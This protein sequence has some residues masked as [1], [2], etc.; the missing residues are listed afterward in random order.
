VTQVQSPESIIDTIRRLASAQKS[1]LGAPAYSRWV[2][3][4]VGRV[5]AAISY[6]AGLTPNQVTT[7][8]AAFSATG[9]AV[10]ALVSPRW[11]TGLLVTICLVL[12]Y[13]FD[14]ADGQLARL[15]GGGSAVGEWLD[16]MVDVTK[17]T[18]L[19]LAVLISVYRFFDLGSTLWYLVPICFAVVNTTTFFGMIL[20]EQLY[21]ARGI[22]KPVGVPASRLRSL[23]VIPTDYGLL[24]LVFL[25]L[26]WHATF[27]AAYTV[28]F[29]GNA[30]FAARWGKWFRDISQ[31][32][33]H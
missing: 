33:A 8:S 24:C 19:H 16:H 26:G 11:W 15:R 4:P 10:L 6:R 2:N 17:I 28:L 32:D 31:L 13:A 12:G 27:L 18:S 5:L 20:N 29:V 25:V 1:S 7:I 14:S 30:V 9:I 23:V 21:R 22:V 3:R